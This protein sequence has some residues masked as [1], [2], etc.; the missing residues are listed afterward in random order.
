MSRTPT[1]LS[2]A[3]RSGFRA[4]STHAEVM[5]Y[6]RELGAAAR[7][8]LH[9]TTF[10]SSAQGRELPLLILSSAGVRDPAAARAVGKPVVLI[11]CCIHAGE[12]EGKEAALMLARDLLAGLDLGL[13]DQMTLLIVPLFNPDGNDAMDPAHRALQIEKLKGQKGPPSSGT[14]VNAAG[15]N[16]NRDY[17]RHEALEMRLMQQHICHAWRPDLTVDTHATNGSVHRF[18]M[19]YDIPHTV[20]SG[21]AEPI[22]YLR[23]VFVPEVSLAV[24]RNAGFDSGWYGNFVEDERV[25]DRS[26]T[27]DPSSAVGEGWM[28]YPHHPR[29]GSNYRG[30]GGRLDL[31]LECYSY[32]GFEERVHTTYAW[33]HEILRAVGR[34]ASEITALV[35]RCTSP[36][37]RVAVRYRLEARPEPVE[38]L[39]R[40]PRTLE[41]EP[42]RLH[43]PFLARFVGET[44]IDRP[45]SY[46]VPGRLGEFLRGHGLALEPA[47][48]AARVQSATLL[49]LG[50]TPGRAI[51]EAAGVGQ[52][53]VGWVASTRRL[54]PDALLLRTEQPLGALAVYLCEPESDDGLVEGGYVPTPS[55]GA[56][57]EV[58][59]WLE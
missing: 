3:E 16:L 40:E 19:T 23:Q 37:A 38:I 8:E 30:L 53:Q 39:T 12:V 45:L 5:A 13:L 58:L 57:F 24:R 6:V 44:L 26:G 52:R 50:A 21:R 46:V 29:F 10:G 35:G 31:L 54:P 42:V 14:R 34:R 56:E 2:V 27:A 22:D 7:P 41:G 11:Q 43:M 25:L 47:P 48:A 17:I 9:V 51:L 20:E 36:R 33:L 32:L 28:T 18:A 15:I 55:V 49:G 1:L 4:T 59:R